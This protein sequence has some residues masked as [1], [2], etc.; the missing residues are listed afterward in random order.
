MP[1]D[2]S[3]YIAGLNSLVVVTSLLFAISQYFEKNHQD[4]TERVRSSAKKVD[5]PELAHADFSDEKKDWDYLRNLKPIRSTLLAIWLFFALLLLIFG[6]VSLWSCSMHLSWAPK[7]LLYYT[8]GVFFTVIACGVFIL[9]LKVRNGKNDKRLE[10]L[11]DK[12][13]V[14]HKTVAV[15]KNV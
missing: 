1:L 11:E 13:E 14:F 15:T 8:W 10:K 7:M 9:I 4:N 6:Y 3:H 5:F 2:I 12:M